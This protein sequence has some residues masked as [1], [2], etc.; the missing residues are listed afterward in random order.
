[1]A[2]QIS[3]AN[4]A[5]TGVLAKYFGTSGGA[6]TRYYWVQAIYTGGLSPLQGA[7]V[8]TALAAL[9]N[10]NRVQVEWNA[11][12]GA[13]GYNV[14]YTTTSTAPTSGLILIGTVTYPAFTDNGSS[15]SPM[16]ATVIVG[17][18]SGS[19]VARAAFSFANDGGAIGLITLSLSD[20]IPA[21]AI[22]TGGFIYVGTALTSGGS[23]IISV[24]TSAGSSASALLAATAV[25]SFSA[26]AVI[27]LVP[28]AAV[29]VRM[30]AAGTVTIT[31]AT[32]ALT[33][34]AFTVTIFYS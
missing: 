30:T 4:V 16:Q 1:M 34:G 31:V 9:D 24:G 6:T 27:P 28:T 17:G 7:P 32:A 33:A 5:P 19:T 26:N 23:A 29:P 25:A 10:N 21:G 12:A 13:I 15:N 3:Y 2:Q 14:F 8:V 18:A 11:M 20:L 22:I